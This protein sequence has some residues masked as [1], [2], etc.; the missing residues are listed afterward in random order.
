MGELEDGVLEH[1]WAHESVLQTLERLLARLRVNTVALKHDALATGQAARYAADVYPAL[2]RTAEKLDVTH[3]LDLACGTGELL[4]LLAEHSKRIVGVGVGSDGV[5]VRQANDLI[6]RRG[7]EKRLIAVPAG[8]VEVCTDTRATFDRTGITT[9]LW[10]RLDGLVGCGVLTAL[11]PQGLDKVRQVLRHIPQ[12]FPGAAFI[13]AEPCR[14]RVGE[15]LLC[16][17]NGAAAASGPRQ[18]AGGE[19]MA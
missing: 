4:C 12:S 8:A 1:I 2:A 10:E 19:G 13:I 7:L 9:Q 18:P 3:V 15:E 5:M 17:G 11:L 6:S 16:P 14:T